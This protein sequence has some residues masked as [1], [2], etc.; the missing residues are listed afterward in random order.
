MG[1]TRKYGKQKQ[2]KIKHKSKR[3]G[4][5]RLGSKRL[6]SKRLGS[7]RLG[8]KRLGSKR[9][10]PKRL[11]PKRLGKGLEETALPYLL[12]EKLN[13][14]SLRSHNQTFNE[15]MLV[16]L[17]L[18]DVP[19]SSVTEALQNAP[20]KKEVARLLSQQF[21]QSANSHAIT[22]K[23]MNAIPTRHLTIGRKR[24]DLIKK[25]KIAQ[26][27][28]DAYIVESQPIHEY[29]EELY[30]KLGD[31]EDKHDEVEKAIGYSKLDKYDDLKIKY[32]ELKSSNSMLD[33]SRAS[34]MRLRLNAFPYTIIGKQLTKLRALEYEISKT[35]RMYDE[36][37]A[38]SLAA[39]EEEDRLQLIV[40][41]FKKQLRDLEDL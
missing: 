14:T 2:V 37:N 15:P 29:K 30:N 35:D 28:L 27:V 6:G 25:L 16:S 36:A 34:I 26:S 20:Y 7:K 12:R 8:S 17:I 1:K 4:S 13:N 38:H 5:K 3:L 24:Q 40:H 39:H 21:K 22:S 19:I 11:G 10:G 18:Q 32:Y 41:N 9:L 31:L 33:R 23:I